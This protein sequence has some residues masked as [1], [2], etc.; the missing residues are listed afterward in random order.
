MTCRPNK[1]GGII[2]DANNHLLIVYGRHSEKWSVPK[3]SLE[4]GEGYLEGALREI[5]EETGLKLQPC[6]ISQLEY[7]AVN[8]A[9]LYLL[10]VDQK[11][12]KL[13][14]RDDEEIINAMWL[15]MTDLDELER[16]KDSSNKMLLAVL[17]KL[18]Y[19]LNFDYGRKMF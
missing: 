12:P 8:H 1:V 15:D 10:Q 6:S 2:L 17:R 4:E 13:K 7:W 11:Q 14:T 9:R 18:S 5:R 19:S 3:G 16:I